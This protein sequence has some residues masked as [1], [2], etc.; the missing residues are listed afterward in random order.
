[1]GWNH[2][3]FR[4]TGTF[5]QLKSGQTLSF[6]PTVEAGWSRCSQKLASLAADLQIKKEPF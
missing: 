3:E 4:K 1:M 2:K 6:T 5:M